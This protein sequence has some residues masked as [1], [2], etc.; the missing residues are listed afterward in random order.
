[1]EPTADLSNIGGYLY[2][3]WLAL[4]FPK[5]SFFLNFQFYVLLDFC[6]TKQTNKIRYRWF[7]EMTNNSGDSFWIF[8]F[9]KYVN[10]WKVSQLFPLLEKRYSRN[11]FLSTKII[12]W[13]KRGEYCSN[14]SIIRDSFN[15]EAKLCSSGCSLKSV[16]IIKKCII[17][18]PTIYI[19]ILNVHSR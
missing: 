13:E 18:P 6:K 12:F 1:M 5:K 4:T 19:I 2:N 15:S 3:K 14:P 8:F 16:K 17:S 7:Q 9:L 10:R 11:I